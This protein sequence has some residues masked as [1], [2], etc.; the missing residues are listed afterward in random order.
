MLEAIYPIVE[1]YGEV[2][3]VPVLLR[4][5]AHEVFE[6][7]T[8]DVHR[9]HRLSKGQILTPPH[10]ENAVELAARKM[11]TYQRKALILLLDSDL[12]CPAEIGIQLQERIHQSR[13]DIPHSVVLPKHEFEAWFLAAARSLR[14]KN[15]VLT[16]ADPPDDPEGIIGAKEYLERRLME[17]GASYSPTVD[18]PAL[19]SYF[20]FQEARVC[21]SFRKLEAD[22]QRLFNVPA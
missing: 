11:S 6:N 9:A 22:L 19:S 7:Y 4:R 1:G 18:Q 15:S 3:A 12:D 5:F 13:P 20:S 2:S 16:T 21:R 17:G 8:I 14:G 10:L